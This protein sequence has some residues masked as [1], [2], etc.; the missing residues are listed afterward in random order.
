MLVLT[1][2][3]GQSIK[4]GD[5]IEVTIMEVEEDKVSI[6]I[7]APRNIEIVRSE[8][9]EVKNENITAANTQKDSMVRLKELFEKKSS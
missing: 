4:I 5:N 7:L 1:R 3:K 2:K 9:L 8:L 6:G